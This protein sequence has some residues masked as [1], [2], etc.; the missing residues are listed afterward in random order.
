MREPGALLLGRK[1]DG[2]DPLN[3]EEGVAAGIKNESLVLERIASGYYAVIEFP[4]NDPAATGFVG[5]R[6]AAAVAARY[7]PLSNR[8]NGSIVYVGSRASP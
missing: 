6:L 3:F 4:P 8:P 1:A 5:P 2:V 7:Q